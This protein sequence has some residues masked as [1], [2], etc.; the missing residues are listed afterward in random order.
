MGALFV[1][2]VRAPLTAVALAIEM[3]GATGIFIPLL[4]ACVGA[5]VVPAALG[6]PPIYDRLGER[7]R[8]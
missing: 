8:A 3:T 5:L 1:A 4:T 2:V 6:S 7:Q